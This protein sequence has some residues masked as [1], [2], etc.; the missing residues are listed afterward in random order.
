MKLI[1]LLFIAPYSVSTQITSSSNL[2]IKNAYRSTLKIKLPKWKPK[3]AISNYNPSIVDWR[4][5]ISGCKATCRY[6]KRLCNFYIRAAAHDS[7]SISEGFGGADGSVLL[8][9]D[10]INRSENKYDSW[11]FLLSQ[12][13]LALAQLYNT[14]VADIISVCGAVATEFQGGP[15]IVKHEKIQP[16]LVGRFDSIDP[17]P[18]NKLPGSNINLEGFADFAKYRNLTMEEMTALMGSHSLID[19]RG[20]ERTNGG[21]CDPTNEAC[22]DLKIYK[23]SNQYYRDVCSPNILIN[24]PPIRSSKPLQKL[25]DIRNHNTCKFTSPELRA[26]AIGIFDAE[27]KILM[28]VQKPDA[29]VINLDTEMEDVSWFNKNLTTRNWVYTV[30]DAWMGLACQRNVTQTPNNIEIGKAMNN[31]QISVP[32]WDTAYIIGYKKM[33]NTG[34][35]WAIPGGLAITGDECPSGYLSTSKTIR[36]NKCSEISRRDGT[37]NCPLNC[38]CV[39]GMSNNAKFYTTIIIP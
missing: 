24:I 15:T 32:A 25:K 22:T 20:C 3:V 8:T 37:Y 14:S 19:E 27:I 16:F 7:F 21:I 13:A 23:W 1:S 11:A 29:L 4:S 18:A 28:G 35:N 10:E 38:K 2:L 9:A 39:T 33:I 34:A 5:V 30:H 12:N 31:F 36:C 17:N 6:D 26:R